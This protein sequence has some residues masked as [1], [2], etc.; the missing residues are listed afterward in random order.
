MS[1][2]TSGFALLVL[3]AS[4]GLA[5]A[6]A[7]MPMHAGSLTP[8]SPGPAAASCGDT[9]SDVLCAAFAFVDGPHGAVPFAEQEAGW[10]VGATEALVH[11]GG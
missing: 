5:G 8:T 10:A 11:G 3:L 4:C 1:V 6:G 9:L 2:A 7:T